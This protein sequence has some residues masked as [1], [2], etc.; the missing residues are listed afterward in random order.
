MT[1]SPE[2]SR[3]QE[4]Y[5]KTAAQNGAL[6][7][8]GLISGF[9]NAMAKVEIYPISELAKVAKVRTI[10]PE[11][12]PHIL[13]WAANKETRKHLEP[14][15]MVPRNIFETQKALDDLDGYYHNKQT[16]G[17]LEP[18]KIISL[19][20][21]NKLDIPN[22]VLTIRLRGDPY[23]TDKEQQD[24]KVAG[25]ERLIVNPKLQNR[26]IAKTLVATVIEYL[27]NEFKGYGGKGAKAIRAWVM[28]GKSSGGWNKNFDLFGDLGFQVYKKAP[29]WKEYA[30]KRKLPYIEGQDALWLETTSELYEK[31]K[32]ERI[33]PK[34][35]EP[36][37]RPC[38]KLVI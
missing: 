37:I 21:T 15:P 23:I 25:I 1:K 3:G 29:Q 16:D 35:G 14:P 24:K 4:L 18:K 17:S 22:G 8:D 19:V 26:G 12:Y 32:S 34:T 6:N 33:D 9:W 31:A 7:V 36:K 20:S 28:T 38:K 2:N 5:L 13:K 30:K 10:I 11:D 27:F